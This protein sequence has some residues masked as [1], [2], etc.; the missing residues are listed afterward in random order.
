MVNASCLCGDVVYRLEGDVTHM[1]HCHCSMCRKIHGS[2]FATY[3]GVKK[4]GFQWVHGAERVVS[5]ESSPGFMRAFCPTCGSVAPTVDEEQDVFVPAGNLLDDCG[6]RPQAHIF[7][8]SGASWYEITDDLPRFDAYPPGLDF[9]VIEQSPRGTHRPGVVGGS[10]LCGAVA[11]EYEG[12]PKF[13]M[14]CHCTRCRRAK[15]AAHA[16]NVFVD[17]ASFRWLKGED[18]VTSYKL[19]EAER[20]GHAFCRTCGSS[21]PRVVAG[22]PLVN[23]P[24]G[25]LDDDPGVRPKAHIFIGSKAPWFEPSDD[26]PKFDEMPPRG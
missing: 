1:T 10:C 19:P 21:M 3:A 7:V 26:L 17:A 6:A 12:E 4:S 20:F 15:S 24:A 14:N 8:T 18:N 22:A 23:V 5:Y 11:F 2:A 13:M 25:A 16:S 9:P